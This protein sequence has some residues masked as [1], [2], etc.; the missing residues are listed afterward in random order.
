MVGAIAI[1]GLA[2]RLEL[3]PD[4]ASRLLAACEQLQ[5]TLR[6]EGLNL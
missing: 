5:A 4:A 6:A 3:D 1:A 2:E